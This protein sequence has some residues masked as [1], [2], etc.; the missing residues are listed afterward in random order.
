[1]MGRPG[2][3]ATT[4]EETVVNGVIVLDGGPPLPEGVRVVVELADVDDIGPPPEPYDRE[5]ELAILR[6]SIEDARA[7]RVRPVREV[8]HEI[9]VRDNLPLEPGE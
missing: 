6:E 2:G 5:R 1:M 7:G 8:L 9:A 3:S 4:R